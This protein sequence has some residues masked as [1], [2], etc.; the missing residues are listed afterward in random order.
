MTE[1]D[2]LDLDPW[3]SI[4]VDEDDQE[5]FE[6]FGIEPW[7][8]DE[9]EEFDH[10]LA[11][12]GM[13]IGHR[14][15]DRVY[16]N[17]EDGSFINMTG[18]ASS[19]DLH[20]GHKVVL[21]LFTHFQDQGAE[22]Y[23]AVA[24]LDALTTRDDIESLDQV[25]ESVVNNLANAMSLGVDPENIYL[26]SQKGGSYKN[27]AF[28][29][30][31]AMTFNEFE[32]T[33][34]VQDGDTLG[35]AS[36]VML[37]MADILHG[38]LPENEGQMPSITAVSLDQDP[39]MRTVRDVARKLPY[40]F[41]APS[42]IYIAQQAGLQEG[43]KMSSSEP[44]TAIFLDD[45][46]DEMIAK[47]EGAKTGGR[48]SAEKQREMGGVPEDCKVYEAALYHLDDDEAVEQMF[49]DCVSGENL[50]G[51]C[52]AIYAPQIAEEVAEAVSDY[53]ANVAEAR[54]LVA[55]AYDG[56]VN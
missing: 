31:D 15:F 3:G 22:T 51:E 37:Q 8:D 28:E 25:E 2:E 34:G 47:L 1:D 30:G 56:E 53:E 6:Q 45:S 29:S 16:D 12:R 13:V 52:K 39:H 46:Y 19:G 7:D 9:F 49:E 14:D 27:L 33:Y 26:Q 40:E 50:C 48:S 17:M 18:I 11:D 55:E 23:F 41:D 4:E 42:S 35:K 24:D 5:I 43:K 20:M 32:S 38:Q 54:Q 10:R 36:G 44:E 21:D